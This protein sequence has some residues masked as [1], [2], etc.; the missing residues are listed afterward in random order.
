MIFKIKA[1][2]L[3]LHSFLTK[4][5]LI[6]KTTQS[7]IKAVYT[8]PNRERSDQEKAFQNIYFKDP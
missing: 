8:V 5:P 3:Q 6:E 1:T 2:K 4:V 7:T